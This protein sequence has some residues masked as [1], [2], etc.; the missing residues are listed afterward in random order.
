MSTNPVK[1]DGTYD[2]RTTYGRQSKGQS[3][4]PKQTER[5]F[6]KALKNTN[7]PSKKAQA[8]VKHN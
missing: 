6:E 7:K 3:L 5:Q 4:H 8:D 2:G 1:N